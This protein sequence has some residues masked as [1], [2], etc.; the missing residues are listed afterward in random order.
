MSTS[1]DQRTPWWAAFSSALFLLAMNG[2]AAH[3]A[4][5][6]APFRIEGSYAPERVESGSFL[7]VTFSADGTFRLAAECR[8]D[9]TQVCL[10]TGRYVISDAQDTL[11]LTDDET[12]A[13]R[14]LPFGVATKND[15][16][17]TQSLHT[18][19]LVGTEPSGAAPPGLI[20]EKD[21]LVR[22]RVNSPD[23][24]FVRSLTYLHV[25]ASAAGGYDNATSVVGNVAQ[26]V[27]APAGH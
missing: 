27:G 10:E 4:G 1:V 16:S 20:K 13:A 21:P 25:G 23:V 5:P 15:S 2:C 24:L 12:G 7:A 19:D 11:Q 9:R 8:S 6:Q 22:E 18:L 17:R 26:P 3:D 14:S